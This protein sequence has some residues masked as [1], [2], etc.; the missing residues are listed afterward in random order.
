MST[1]AMKKKQ[2]LNPE[3]KEPPGKVITQFVSPQGEPT[4][5]P[6]SPFCCELSAVSCLL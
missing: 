5:R 2:K 6:R 1:A 3:P 4:V